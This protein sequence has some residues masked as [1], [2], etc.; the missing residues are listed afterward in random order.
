MATGR[1]RAHLSV[2]IPTYNEEL[3]LPQSL[4]LV[5]AYLRERGL[6]AEIL[7]VDDGSTD[8][9]ARV[10]AELLRGRRGRVIR[11]PENRGKGH[12]LR[13]GVLQ[14][15]GRWAL[16]TDADLSVPIGEHAKLA[17]AARDRDLDIVIGSRAL[18][19]S[20]IE[21]PAPRL[22]RLLN[23]ALDRVG[24]RIAGLPFGDPR[25]AFKLVDRERAAVLFERM[26]VDRVAFDFELLFVAARFGLHLGEVP[27]VWRAAPDS[28][29]RLLADPPRMLLD[30]LRVRW[31]FRRGGYSGTN[32][33]G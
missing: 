29:V 9:T 30:L 16:L 15:E 23:G 18:P 12:A 13:E 24:R 19:G 31:R 22:H 10:A 7:V 5:D 33:G 28:R 6:D 14:A 27:V 17:A 4:P 3:R 32:H 1:V 20:R 25:C 21:A 8:D 2:I 26:I 11:Q